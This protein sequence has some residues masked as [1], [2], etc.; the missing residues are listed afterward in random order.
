MGAVKRVDPVVARIEVFTHMTVPTVPTLQSRILQ[1]L[2]YTDLT[3]ERLSKILK[4]PVHREL[5]RMEKEGLVKK[6]VKNEE[7]R[8]GLI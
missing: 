8:W 6:V 7:E 1:E 5:A 4:A 2:E 3:E